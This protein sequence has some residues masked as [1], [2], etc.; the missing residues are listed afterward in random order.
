LRIYGSVFAFFFGSS[1]EHLFRRW[2][3]EGQR[4][5]MFAYLCLKKNQIIRTSIWLPWK[6]RELAF[7]FQTT[8]RKTRFMSR[9]LRIYIFMPLFP[10]QKQSFANRGKENK[11]DFSSLCFLLAGKKLF[12]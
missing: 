3:E 9:F 11:P 12:V 4:A 7:V 8:D 1:A 6:N 5:G 2:A 10:G